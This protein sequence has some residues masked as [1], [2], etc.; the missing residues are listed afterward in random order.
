MKSILFITLIASLLIP[1]LVSAESLPSAKATARVGNISLLDAE[2]MDWSTIMSSKIKT[3]NKKELMMNV[4]LECGLATKT[5][6]KSKRGESDTSSAEASVLV[7]VLVDGKE[8]APGVISFCKRS[9]ELTA[10]FG[11]VMESC[12]DANGDGTITIDECIFTDEELELVL[13]TMNANAFNFI[14]ANI[15]TGVHEIKVQAKIGS[16][17]SSMSGSAE[18]KGSIGKGA[19][20][21]EEVR[22]IKN[23]AI[24][25]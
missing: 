21:I 18:A 14:L 16:K 10:V 25:F 22:M 15:S 11:G 4:S 17:T 20:T 3:S 12:T 13:N 5:R 2:R 1:S 23:D 9:Q 7:R 24:E 6:V 19:I 8:A